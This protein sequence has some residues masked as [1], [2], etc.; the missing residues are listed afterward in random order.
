MIV[1][2]CISAAMIKIVDQYQKRTRLGSR[3]KR[4]SETQTPGCRLC[5]VRDYIYNIYIL[6]Y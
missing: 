4:R 5:H 2:A 3:R 1:V 6:Q